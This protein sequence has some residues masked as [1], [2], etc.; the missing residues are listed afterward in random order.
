MQRL[1]LFLVLILMSFSAT[2]QAREAICYTP[3][4]FE[5]EQGLRIQSELMVIALTCMK[6]PGGGQAMYNKYQ[7][8]NSKHRGLISGYEAEM[9]S[10]FRG[11]G[12]SANEAAINNFK[13]GLANDISQHAIRTS[14]AS[15]CKQFASRVDQALSMDQPKVR[16][17]AQQVWPKS[18]TSRPLCTSR[19]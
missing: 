7:S 12:L 15:F 2:A 19:G 13:T 10:F 3:A 16:R 5:A 17:W 18:P 4:Q 8:F 14:T 9:I 11:N 6:A 1:M